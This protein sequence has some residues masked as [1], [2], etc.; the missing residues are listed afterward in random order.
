MKVRLTGSIVIGGAGCLG[1]SMIVRLC[2]SFFRFYFKIML[3]N[4]DQ[5]YEAE[6]GEKW[7]NFIPRLGQKCRRNPIIGYRLSFPFDP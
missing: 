2:S 4:I 3:A 7:A 6:F 1:R 5:T